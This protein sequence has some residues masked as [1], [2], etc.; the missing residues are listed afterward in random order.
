M[1]PSKCLL[2]DYIYELTL[3]KVIT[4]VISSLEPGPAVQQVRSGGR[5]YL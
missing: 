4:S 1:I 2:T 5:V 3:S